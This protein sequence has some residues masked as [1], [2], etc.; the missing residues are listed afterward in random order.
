M[1]C[2]QCGGWIFEDKARVGADLGA[3][4][5]VQ[6]REDTGLERGGGVGVGRRDQILALLRKLK[7]QDLAVDWR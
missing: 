2:E 4:I 7:L 3:T 1:H 6:A 5:P